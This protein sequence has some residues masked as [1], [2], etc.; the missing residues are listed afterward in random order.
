MWL[1]CGTL[2]VMQST[3]VLS[4][5]NITASMCS[6]MY[7]RFNS[8]FA[9][10]EYHYILKAADRTFTSRTTLLYVPS[11]PVKVVRQFQ[12]SR[13]RHWP[14]A[15]NQVDCHFLVCLYN[16]DVRLSRCHHEQQ[17]ICL[18]PDNLHEFY[19]EKDIP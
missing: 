8:K 9:I 11:K 10:A 18:F 15:V 6:G 1:C 12:E 13:L 17:A 14:Q 4:K 2:G 5:S 7:A 16:I 3:R 19:R